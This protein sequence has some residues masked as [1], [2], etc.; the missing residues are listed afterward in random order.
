[1]AYDIVARTWYLKIL[2][3]KGDSAD[4]VIEIKNK[5]LTSSWEEFLK[6][7][8]NRTWTQVY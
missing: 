3:D 8:F 2:L 4:L 6:T 7:D 1:V 5:P